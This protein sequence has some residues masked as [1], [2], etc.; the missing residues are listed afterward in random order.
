MLD[1]SVR[2]IRKGVVEEVFWS[3]VTPSAD[4][5]VND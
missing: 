1:G 5:I 3:Q 2:L 4:D